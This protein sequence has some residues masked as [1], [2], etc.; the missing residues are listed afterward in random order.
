MK[1]LLAPF[2][3]GGVGGIYGQKTGRVLAIQIP[4]G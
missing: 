3:K 4:N 2:K 1:I